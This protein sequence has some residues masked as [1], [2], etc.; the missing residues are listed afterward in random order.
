MIRLT[1]FL[2]LTPSE[3]TRLLNSAIILTLIKL[4]LLTMSLATVRRIISRFAYSCTRVR[5][6]SQPSCA[7]VRSIETASRVIPGT[8]NC[9]VRAL[10]AELLLVRSG[11]HC[12]LK[13][14]VARSAE[15][16]FIAHAWVE[17]EDRVLIGHPGS[18]R[19]TPLQD[20][21]PNCCSSL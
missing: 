4:G 12:E 7:I 20:P 14:G 3:R 8:R 19:Y 17:G 13:F 16:E 2:I 6:P 21:A 11:C 5:Q 15:G 9:L 10:A 1:K 18:I